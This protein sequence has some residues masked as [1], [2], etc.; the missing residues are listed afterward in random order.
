MAID[1]ESH[2]GVWW[3]IQFSM[4]VGTARMILL[5][6]Q[7]LI[8]EFAARL[9]N[10][11]VRE[12]DFEIVLHN[13][14]ADLPI[15]ERFLGTKRFKY[16][17][18]MQE[19][20]GFGNLPQRLKAL[21]RRLLGRKRESWEEL[22]TPPS[23]ERLLSWMMQ[24]FVHC[25]NELQQSIPRFHKKSGKPLKPTIVRSNTEKLL[26]EL[27]NYSLNSTDYPVWQKLSERV[28]EGELMM[29]KSV[30]GPIPQ[31]GIAN[32]GLDE[33]VEYGCSDA[34][35]TLALALMFER[36]RGEMVERMNLQEED[37]DKPYT[38]STHAHEVGV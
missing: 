28:P 24:G 25:E 2:D 16:R 18:T 1:T 33:A 37:V 4:K 9:W 6:D 35:D 38:H 19:A 30:L 21:S 8:R 15:I 11:I 27:L 22:V 32:V 12:K 14:P 23:K 10:I 17:D 13:A 26:S 20:Y 29:L 7:D 3:S 34:D 31:K 5:K 36:M